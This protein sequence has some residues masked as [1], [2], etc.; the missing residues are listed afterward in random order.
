MV[1]KVCC[2]CGDV[3]QRWEIICHADCAERR[4]FVAEIDLLELNDE[5]IEREFLRD[6]MSRQ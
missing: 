4:G 1:A 2:L 5:R 6:E 3:L